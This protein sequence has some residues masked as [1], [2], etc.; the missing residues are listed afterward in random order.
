[1][2]LFALKICM[3]APV[4][5]DFFF[6]NF[7][8]YFFCFLLICILVVF[9]YRLYEGTLLPQLVRGK[10]LLGQHPHLKRVMKNPV[11]S[12][13]S[14][15]PEWSALGTFNPAAF[16]DG[17]RTHIVYRA[18]GLDGVSRLGYASSPDGLHFD[19]QESYPV[20]SMQNPRQY[21]GANAGSAMQRYDPVMY[22]SGGS[23]GGCEDPR[24]VNIDG[25]IY[26]TFSAFDGWDFIRIGLISIRLEDLKAKKWKWTK[27]LLDI[28]SRQ[29]Q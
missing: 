21:S 27:P 26:I 9:L 18:I 20:F 6:I 17:D 25:R 19:A 15:G 23:W 7:L 24:M 28:S 22:P 2:T 5:H 12:P 14:S 3:D 8:I 11:L 13:D 4:I 16:H 29:S 10:N 1:M